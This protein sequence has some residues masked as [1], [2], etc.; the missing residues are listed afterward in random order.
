MSSSIIGPD[1]GKKGN[2]PTDRG[3]H[4]PIRILIPLFAQGFQR[5]ERGEEALF[6][7]LP[8][9]RRRRKNCIGLDESEDESQ[10]F[11]WAEIQEDKERSNHCLT[12]DVQLVGRSPFSHASLALGSTSIST[13]FLYPKEIARPNFAVEISSRCIRRSSHSRM[14]GLCLLSR[15]HTL[16]T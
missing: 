15:V 12:R 5:T 14:D 4:D 9:A 2:G 11:W 6:N 13:N 1:Q 7:M 3:G 10:N 16:K 8:A